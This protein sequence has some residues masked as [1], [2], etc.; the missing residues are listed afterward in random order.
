MFLNNVTYYPAFFN[1]DDLENIDHY[2][3]ETGIM[4]PKD[5][6]ILGEAEIINGI[7]KILLKFNGLTYIIIEYKN[8]SDDEII[9]RATDKSEFKLFL[10]LYNEKQISF[11]NLLKYSLK[12]F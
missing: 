9:L 10:K 6:R 3:Y 12:I 4:I 7:N 8:K 1:I 11:I 2:S 5:E